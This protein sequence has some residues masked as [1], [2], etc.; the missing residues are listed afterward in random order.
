MRITILCSSERHPVNAML[1]A[2]I[3]KQAQKH[4]VQLIRRKVELVEG[5]LLLLVSCGEIINAMDRARF[6]KTLVLHASDLPHGRGWNPYIWEIIDGAERITVT[7]LEAEDKVDTGNI[8][9]KLVVPIARHALHDEINAALFAAEAEL[10]DFAVD[11]FDSVEPIPQSLVATS[12]PYRLRNPADS[13]IDPFR[14]IASQFD[15]IRVC[16]P[17]RY[18]AFFRL[19]GHTYRL[20]VEKHEER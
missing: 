11:R 7:L 10:L 16:D 2:W 4:E 14:D 1:S 12:Q 5:D 9:K 19:H 20:R 3:R 17:Q 13:E 6:R 8:W 15:L 18:P